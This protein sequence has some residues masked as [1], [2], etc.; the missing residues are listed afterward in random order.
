M[1]TAPSSAARRRSL[2]D[3]LLDDLRQGPAR[4]SAAPAP[5]AWETSSRAEVPTDIALPAAATPAVELRITPRSW[6]SA[7]WTRRPEGDGLTLSLGPVC[8]SLGRL[9]P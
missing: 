1:T 8:L 3:D 7:G 5:V 6:S 2:Q 4:S 9:R